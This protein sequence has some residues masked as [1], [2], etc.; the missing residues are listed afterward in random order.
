MLHI[1]MR[2]A[3]CAPATRA[4]QGAT[5]IHVPHTG[6]NRCTHSVYVYL[7]LCT[8]YIHISMS[9]HTLYTYIYVYAYFIFIYLCLCTLYIHMESVYICCVVYVAMCR[10]ANVHNLYTGA[11]RCTLYTHI[12]CVHL[13]PLLPPIFRRRTFC[14]QRYVCYI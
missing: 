7:C 9:M 2:G 12:E 3:E 5:E 10:S 14:I 8:F 11:N 6:G 13:L 4:K 1:Q